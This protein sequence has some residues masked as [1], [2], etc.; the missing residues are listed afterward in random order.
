MPIAR[1]RRAPPR[2]NSSSPARLTRGQ[3]D[4]T[5]ARMTTL[6]RVL[7]PEVMDSEDEARAYDAMDHAEVN[8]AFCTDLLALSPR[9]DLATTLDVG[10]GTAL[11]P[12]ELCHRAKDARVVGIDLAASMLAVGRRNVEHAAL[13]GVVALRLVD[14]K[15]LPFADKSFRCVV[16]N[17]IVHHIPEPLG[18]LREMLRVL[19][20]GGWLFV[21]DLARPPSDAAVTELL[22]RYAQGATPPQRAL[23]DASLRAALTVD[24]VRDRAATTGLPGECVSM[25][26]DRHW[27]LA[28]RRAN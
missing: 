6:S 13:S 19:S 1:W 9:P 25:S 15:A 10:T 24:E 21:R 14:A 20:P 23:L 28:F 17:S 16:S 5:M 26:S 4:T 2:C 11:I 27:T 8:A 22:C 18:T 7:E 3:A 12:I